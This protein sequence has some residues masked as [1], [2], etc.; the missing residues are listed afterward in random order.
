[1][2]FPK[3]QRSSTCP[4][5]AAGHSPMAGVYRSACLDPTIAYPKMTDVQRPRQPRRTAY[6]GTAGFQQLRSL[7][8]I[9][10]FWPVRAAATLV[11]M[12]WGCG[13]L[14]FLAEIR[15]ELA[16]CPAASPLIDPGPRRCSLRLLDDVGRALELRRLPRVVVSRSVS[17]PLAFGFL[18]ST[19]VLPD[20]LIGAITDEEMWDVLLHEM[21]HLSRRDPLIV[22]MQEVARALYWPLVRFTP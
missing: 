18:R 8:P 9:E 20:R 6:A 10:W 22:L 4:A 3:R 21:A 11:M 15:A 19:I 14:I 2:W 13:S 5:I 16:A 1:M 7:R 17:T 12:V